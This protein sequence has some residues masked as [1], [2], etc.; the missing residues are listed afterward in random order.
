MKK[1]V[2]T[3]K[4]RAGLAKARRKWQNMSPSARKKAMPGGKRK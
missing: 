2:L 1:Y 3:K 4:R